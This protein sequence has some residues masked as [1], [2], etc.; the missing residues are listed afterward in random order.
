M[1]EFKVTPIKKK[2]KTGTLGKSL[3]GLNSVERTVF[4][5]SSKMRR[6]TYKMFLSLVMF[7]PVVELSVVKLE[8]NTTYLAFMDNDGQEI[9][10]IDS[11]T[12]PELVSNMNKLQVRVG[13]VEGK[14]DKIL[15]TLAPSTS[16][17][18][19]PTDSPTMSPTSAPEPDV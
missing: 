12:I 3:R 10:A 9:S 1:F 15:E 5:P 8:A 19:S 17:T 11:S 16:P 6:I 18:S 7:A 14:V 2:R 4:I 13:V